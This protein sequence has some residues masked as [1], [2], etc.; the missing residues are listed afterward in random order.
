MVR[1]LTPEQL[2]DALDTHKPLTVLD[3][4]PTDERAEWSIPGSL[5][6]D[7]Y[8]SLREGDRSVLTA[9]VRTLPR[10]RPVVTVC[11]RGR[12][13]ALAADA[14]QDLGFEVYSLLG[15]MTAWT[16]AWNTAEVELPLRAPKNVCIIQMRRVGKGCLSYIIV[17]DG[18]AAVVDPA[19][20]PAVY[21]S[22]AHQRGCA[23][24]AV[25]DTHVHADHVTR[26]YELA[27]RCGAQVYLPDQQR[28]T[29]P[30]S[31]LKDGDTIQVGSASLRALRTPGHTHESTC[32]IIDD[33]AV[34]S[35]DTLFLNSVGRPD[36]AASGADEPTQRARAL[37]HSLRER[38]LTLPDDMVIMP[39]HSSA[40]LP[41]DGVAHTAP[42]STV[43]SGVALVSLEE[44][45]FVS[46][47]LA[48]IP[49]T[50]A[51]HLQI[52]RINEGKEQLPADLI[53][54]EA[55]ANRC[56]VST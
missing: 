13:S 24:V 53:S 44:P 3:V 31:P 33:V 45:E 25:V 14:L 51:N 30:F 11:A 20:D 9:A 38:L 10:D 40:A 46:T 32:Y 28:V 42:L 17:S 6:V 19:V 16:G 2:R 47:V 48:R 37:Y 23:I 22:L 36:L 49:P 43:R 34:C 12:T 18:V 15:G 29:R 26:A 5:H 21:L 56:A 55:G 52:V 8:K 39:G 27:D 4:R 35:G 7:A 50:P 1:E 41:F 54:L